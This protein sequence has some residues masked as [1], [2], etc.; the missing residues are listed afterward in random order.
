[1]FYGLF[2]DNLLKNLSKTILMPTYTLFKVGVLSFNLGQHKELLQ[3]K[4]K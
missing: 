4:K 2:L 3:E 1:M